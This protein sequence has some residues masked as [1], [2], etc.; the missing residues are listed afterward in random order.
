MATVVNILPTWFIAILL[1][2][3]LWLGSWLGSQLRQRRN[4]NTETPYATSAA[5]SLLALLIA[6]TFSMSLNR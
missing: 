5:V 1:F 4:I 6:F 2:G 3:L